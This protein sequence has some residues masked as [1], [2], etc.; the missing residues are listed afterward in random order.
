MDEQPDWINEK[1]ELDKVLEDPAFQS[2]IDGLFRYEHVKKITI[3][4]SLVID[5]FEPFTHGIETVGNPLAIDIDV[6][7]EYDDS[8]P[9]PIRHPSNI[10]LDRYARCTATPEVK[11]YLEGFGLEIGAPVVYVPSRLAPNG[12]HGKK[13]RI[14]IESKPIKQNIVLRER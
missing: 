7:L 1:W 11:D 6:S 14:H 5:G 2:F 3:L 8:I 4:G 13:Y 10:F 9:E 12:P